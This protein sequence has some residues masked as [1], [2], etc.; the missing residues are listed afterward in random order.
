MTREDIP[1]NI[2][3]QTR[4]GEGPTSGTR[5]RTREHGA[6][7]MIEF[8]DVKK[9]FS[10]NTILNGLNLGLPDG[11]ISMILGPSGTGKSV[12]I[13]HMVG[14]ALSGC[15]RRAG[16]RRVGA[17]RWPTTTSSRCARSSACCS[18]RAPC[19]DP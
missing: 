14:P 17:P 10:R 4:E 2:I 18:R 13:K 7:D 15:G 16:A 9:S 5:A 6:E 1:G 3:D 11:Q 8:I 12:C 19:S